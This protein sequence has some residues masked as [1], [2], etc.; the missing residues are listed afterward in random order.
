M[1]VSRVLKLFQQPSRVREILQCALETPHW[2]SVTCAFLGF[3]HPAYPLVLP[4]RRGSPILLENLADLKTFWQVFARRVYRVKRSELAILDVGANIG[5]FTLYAARQAP[6]AKI[7]A[8]E[9]FPATFARLQQTVRDHHLENRVT[10][11]QQAVTG[12]SG[13]HLMQD[14][15][16]PSQQRTV[17]ALKQE[18][19]G[20]EV[21]GRTL[22]ELIEECHLD[23]IDLL[24]M[25]IEGSEYSVFLATPLHVLSTIG[26]VA[27]EYHGHCSPYTKQQLFDHLSNAGFRITSD[28]HNAQ[29]YG[30]AEAVA[31]SPPL[32]LPG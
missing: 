28:L 4:L 29:G 5:L 21:Q 22:S 27:L 15:P 32:P 7:I 18:V 11:L 2:A 19:A 10:C 9:P 26:R 8:V 1:A 25:D 14:L 16:L 13:V 20:T 31:T 12:C 3:S 6:I 24:K 23:R 17:I 30:L